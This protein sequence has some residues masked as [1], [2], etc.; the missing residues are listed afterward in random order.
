LFNLNLD[1][2]ALLL[3]SR[4]IMIEFWWG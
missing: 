1:N 3:M 4:E 2:S